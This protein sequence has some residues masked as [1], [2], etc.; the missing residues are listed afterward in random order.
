[1]RCGEGDDDEEACGAVVELVIRDNES[2]PPPALFMTEDW[3]EVCEPDLA[4]ICQLVESV[5][6]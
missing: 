1:M 2:R 3:L 4:P 6:E 5:R